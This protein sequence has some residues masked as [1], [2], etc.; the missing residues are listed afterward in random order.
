MSDTPKQASVK[1]ASKFGKG[2]PASY[3]GKK[4][5]SG[6]AF[7]NINA[8]R[9][10]LKAGKLPKDARYIEF[11]LNAF[12]RTLEEAIVAARGQV[13]IPDAAYVQT[14]IRWERHACLAQRWLVKADATLKAEQKLL[15]SREIA[16]ASA[17]RDKALAMLKLDTDHVKDAWAALDALPK[18]EKG[19]DDGQA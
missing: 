9:H 19:D 16:R 14:A 10:G 13:T 3:C 17:E 2:Q 8:V 6:P 7:G 18:P 11:R 15:F 1:A 5:R 12:R 4:G